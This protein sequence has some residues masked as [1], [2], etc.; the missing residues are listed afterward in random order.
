VKEESKAVAYEV[1]RRSN[2]WTRLLAEE[3]PHAL[4]LSIHPQ[5]PHSDKIGL[6]ITRAVDDWLTP[7]HGVV[8]LRANDYV[9]MKRQQAEALGA[10]LIVQNGQPSHFVAPPN[11]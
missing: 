4:R 1:I 7:W 5:H 9:L 10:E 6:R 8:V 3:L 11:S 2:A